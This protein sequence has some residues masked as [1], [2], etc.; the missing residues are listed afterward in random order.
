MTALLPHQERVVA[1]KNE[2]EVKA[3][4]LSDFI[5]LSEEFSK[6]SRDEKELLREQCEVMWQYFEILAARI[7]LF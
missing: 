6:L 5:G 2:L 4:A 1:E 3:K 7:S